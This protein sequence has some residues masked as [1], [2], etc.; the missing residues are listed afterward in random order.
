MCYQV[1]TIMFVC[2]NINVAGSVKFQF[3]ILLAG[4]NFIVIYLTLFFRVAGVVYVAVHVFCDGVICGALFLLSR[5][6]CWTV[7]HK[8][9]RKCD[10]LIFGYV[11]MWDV[12]R[13]QHIKT[14]KG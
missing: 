7:F 11:N 9:E 14:H 1:L 2:I 10:T 3:Q 12:R 8:K 5:E 13:Y 6:R 4:V